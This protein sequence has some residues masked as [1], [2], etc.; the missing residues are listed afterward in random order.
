MS[1][2]TQGNF[3]RL[4]NWEQ[5]RQNDIEIMS[6]RHD[7]EDDNFAEGLNECFLR[8]GRVAM[9]GNLNVG[10]YQVKNVAQATADNDAVNL[11]QVM[12]VK[13]STINELMQTISSLYY[14]GDIKASLQSADHGVWLLCNG[15]AVS[16]TEYEDLFDLIGTR[17]GSGDGVNTFNLPD[18]RGKFL[19]GLGGNSAADIYTTQAAS[20]SMSN[21]YHGFGYNT[22]NNAGTF[23]AKASSDTYNMPANSGTRS[24]NGSEGGGS[25]SGDVSTYSANMI[26]TL[27]QGISGDDH[28]INQAVNYFIKAKG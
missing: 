3:T 26:T 9:S 10:N 5:D 11:A 20:N 17:F 22:E 18:Y 8:D 21:H 2:D 12:S 28:P 13:E 23:A 6:D 16:R 19:R 27:P 25:Y 4:H 14:L 15:Q 24:W 1:Y 7:E